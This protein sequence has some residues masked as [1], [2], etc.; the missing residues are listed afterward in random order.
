MT[1]KTN[2]QAAL[3]NNQQQ[4][5]RPPINGHGH[6]ATNGNGHPTVQCN[7]DEDEQQE[8][9]EPCYFF[10]TNQA[11]Q[12]LPRYQ[13]HGEDLSLLYKYVLSPLASFCVEHLTPIWLAPNSITLIGL[14][15]MVAAYLAMWYY[16]P[17]L[18]L[19][20][21][22]EEETPRWIFLLN[23]IAIL[24]YQTLDNMDGKQARRTGNGSPL[25]LL[26]D[27]GCDAVNNVFGSANWMIS[28]A[29][30][31]VH[32][33]YLCASILFGPYAL[34]F[35][36]TWE[37]YY[38]GK[39]I[40]PIINGPNEGLMGGAMM[41]FLSFWFGPNIWH[42]THAW[43]LVVYPLVSAVVPQE[44]LPAIGLRNADCLVLFSTYNFFAEPLDKAINVVRHYGGAKTLINLVPFFTL[45]GCASIV[46]ATDLNVWLDMPRTS[47]HLCAALF[48]EMTVELMMCHMTKQRYTYL[49]W[50]LLPLVLLSALVG[51]GMWSAGRQTADFLLIY[52]SGI[53]TYLVFK[54]VVTIHEICSILNI[55]CFDITTKRPARKTKQ[56]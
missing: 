13:Y 38:T 26:F 50:P 17:A 30:H 35:F 48:V 22:E 12:E 42:Q 53:S 39:L 54:T 5:Q 31:P 19:N 46:G 1:L 29:L 25:G 33:V 3:D 10:L 44:W 47:L 28:M 11:A 18:Q 49:R 52:T 55:W 15:F 36:G 24:V 4:A 20:D 8:E 9:S 45:L 56:A 6:A 51:T 7:E 37:E 21:D 14:L 40:M 41:S 27:H 43:D 2:A 32:D 34:F 16:A 23:G